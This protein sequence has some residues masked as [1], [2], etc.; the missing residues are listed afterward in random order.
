MANIP[1]NA[2]FLD[3]IEGLKKE[4]IGITSSPNTTLEITIDITEEYK[5]RR[6]LGQMVF[7]QQKE[8]G[9]EI[10]SLGQIV[11]VTTKNRWH[12]DQS[13]KGVIKHYG[14]LPHL[15]EV[16]D[17]RIATVSIQS[18]FDCTN[19]RAE[20]HILGI[21]PSSGEPARKINNNLMNMLVKHRGETVTRIGTVYG[22]PDVGMPMW[23]KHFGKDESGKGIA[24][25]GAGD[26]YHV[27]VFGKTGSGKS[28]TAAFMLLA[29]AKNKDNMNILV[30]DPQS[31]FLHDRDL[32]PD[33]RKLQ[34]EIENR[35]MKVFRH[36]LVNDIY[37]PSKDEDDVWVFAELLLSRKFIRSAFV[38]TPFDRQKAAAECVVQYIMGRNMN[39]NFNLGKED[40]K[41][42]LQQM[43][44][45][46]KDSYVSYVYSDSNYQSRMKRNIQTFLDSIKNSEPPALKTWRKIFALF[47]AEDSSV[48]GPDGLLTTKKK[49]SI[50]DVVEKIVSAKGGNFFVL[51]MGGQE[52]GTEAE[53]LQALF[54]KVIEKKIAEEGAK[55]YAKNERANCLI[56]M[57]EAHR[58]VNAKSP[59]PRIKE[60]S[61]EIIDA[62]R[63]TRKY[64]IGH[65]FISQSLESLDD[66]IIK[67][68]RVFAFGHGLAIGGEL[69]KIREIANDN[70]AALKLYK[71]FIDP[72]NRR[73]Y[74]FMF[75]GPISPFS[76]TGAPLF[77]EM[78]TNFE[79]YEK[80][81]GIAQK[82]NSDSPSE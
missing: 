46:F 73:Q 72:G 39:P 63:T 28:V 58:Y 75:C 41:I 13:F 36:N 26:A 67:Q 2:A 10:L 82:E 47:S 37:L 29:Y 66:E 4:D 57:D 12:E 33:D 8:D 61:K 34:Q 62:V 21:S 35:G 1:D 5:A 7:V 64:G 68:M 77:V 55:I 48:D 49:K 20:I 6:A 30:L 24:E 38:I 31:Q 11:E 51:G 76:A 42:L 19:S 60:L 78:Y 52:E 71:S 3:L 79:H 74:P 18:S 40:P 45:K 81:N 50:A 25:L 23:F 54:L 56:M 32:L 22:M 27:G 16:A 80:A 69:R 43:L 15:S 17:N 14:K 65:M 70:G 59:D 44:E 9:K 53:N